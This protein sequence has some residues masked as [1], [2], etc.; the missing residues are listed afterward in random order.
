VNFVLAKGAKGDAGLTGPVGPQGVAGPSNVLKIG[1]VASGDVAF[2]SI[3]G[4][5]PSQTLSLV[6]PKAQ[7][8]SLSIG[9]VTAGITASATITGTAPNQVLNL[10]L[11]QAQV[12]Q[13]TS[14]WYNPVNTTVDEGQY[15]TFYSGASSTDYPIIYQWQYSDDPSQGE[16]GWYDRPGG[17]GDSLTLLAR[18]E[19]DG[20]YYRNTAVTPSGSRAVSTIAQLTIIQKPVDISGVRSWKYAALPPTNGAVAFIST[21]LD[22][23]SPNIWGGDFYNRGYIPFVNGRLFTLSHSSADGVNWVPY[24]GGPNDRLGELPFIDRVVYFPSVDTYMMFCSSTVFST[25]L[26]PDL[27]PLFDVSIYS[28][29]YK[30]RDGISWEVDYDF[31]PLPGET[32]FDRWAIHREPTFS[33]DGSEML[34]LTI[35]EYQSSLW[36]TS[37]PD[38]KTLV[39]KWTENTPGAVANPFGIGKCP[40]FWQEING[41]VA[42]SYEVRSFGQFTEYYVDQATKS[43][44]GKSVLT[45]RPNGNDSN[46]N[47]VNY[48]PAL[49]GFAYGMVDGSMAYIAYAE[50]GDFYYTKDPNSTTP[51]IQLKRPPGMLPLGMPAYGN[52]WWVIPSSSDNVTYYTVKDLA[53]TKWFTHNMLSGDFI[54]WSDVTYRTPVVFVPNKDPKL[55]GLFVMGGHWNEYGSPYVRSLLFA[56]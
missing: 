13:Q 51:L 26:G 25:S 8:S 31:L 15:T 21:P 1:T 52:G 3:S 24:I 42:Y 56:E 36:K 39:S 50:D 2:A 18:D 27:Q 6:I 55:P 32:E 7:G 53:D 48:A 54:G 35:N 19:R 37:T 28:A 20:R 14:F 41:V 47:P 11:P 44:I 29:R 33:A 43:A 5:S 34:W 30:S 22:R 40:A 49:L 10:V 4:T 46:G 12:N 9:T 17:G 45:P 38:K 23:K 16:A